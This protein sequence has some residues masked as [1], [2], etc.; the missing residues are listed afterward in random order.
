ML[1]TLLS[2]AWTWLAPAPH[3][4]TGIPQRQT[5]TFALGLCTDLLQFAS[6]VLQA[7]PDPIPPSARNSPAG[8]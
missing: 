7:H 5:V 8:G 6:Q 1:R 3:Y 2:G 4:G